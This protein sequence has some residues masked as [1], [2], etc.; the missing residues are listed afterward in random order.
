MSNMQTANSLPKLQAKP[1]ISGAVL[2]GIGGITALAGLI[3]GGAH[4]ISATRKWVNEMDVPP[5]DLARAKW[6]Q[7][8][9]AAAAGANAWRAVPANAQ[10]SAS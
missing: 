2:I 4:L 10:S 3:V 6:A 1:L 7:T 5:R 8:K 9:A